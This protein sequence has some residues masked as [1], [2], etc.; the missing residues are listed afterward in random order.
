MQREGFYLSLEADPQHSMV[1]ALSNSSS[2]GS[3]SPQ[4]GDVILAIYSQANAGTGF[5][6]SYDTSGVDAIV[7]AYSSTSGS[8]KPSSE[9]SGAQESSLTVA[10]DAVVMVQDL[11]NR[12]QDLAYVSSNPWLPDRQRSVLQ[13]EYK[14]TVAQI[15]SVAV[16]TSYGG[17]KLFDGTPFRVRVGN[18]SDA[19][20][21][22]GGID[23]QSL[24]GS[25]GNLDIS[26]LQGSFDAM[27]TVQQFSE[28]VMRQASRSI[29]SAENRLSTIRQSLEG[30]LSDGNSSLLEGATVSGFSGSGT[31]A[32]SQMLQSYQLS[33]VSLIGQ[34]VASKNIS[35]FA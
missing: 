23:L 3:S 5:P 19:S 29:D 30:L 4:A 25:L 17:E 22:A 24:T 6:T 9:S 31:L 1:S 28:H 21:Q 26:T 35:M 8:N 18:G 34:G 20:I 15:E 2:S 14:A 27:D 12:L 33:L 32:R 13:T 16:S 7:A 10:T 11:A